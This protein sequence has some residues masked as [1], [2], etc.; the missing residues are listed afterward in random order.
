[1]RR[2]RALIGGEDGTAA[3]EFIALGCVLLLPLV[4]LVLALGTVQR[5]A[6][7]AESVARHVA[8][9]VSHAPD[10]DAARTAA[11]AVVQSTAAEYGLDEDAFL[12]EMTCAPATS[13]CPAAGTMLTVVVRA[14]IAL[15]LAPPILGL[16]DVA[17]LPV[18]AR[19]VQRVSRSWGTP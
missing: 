16:H 12:I 8:R 3:L 1:M 11:G 2:A 6:L 18:E 7:G 13:A 9:V 14:R 15:P 4:Y 17:A 5:G 19:A 10:V